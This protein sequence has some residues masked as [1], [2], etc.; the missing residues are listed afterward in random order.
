[1]AMAT[2]PNRMLWIAF[3][4]IV[5]TVASCRPQLVGEERAKADLA[6]YRKKF[7]IVGNAMYGGRSFQISTS[8]AILSFKLAGRRTDIGQKT[9]AVLADVVLQGSETF[10]GQLILNYKL[11]D[12]GWYLES[13]DKSADFR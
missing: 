8:E 12:Q 2:N 13:V 10:S 5:A 1:M 6:S 3:C 7:F 11:F 4:L 9:D